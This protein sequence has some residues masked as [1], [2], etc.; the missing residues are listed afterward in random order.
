MFDTLIFGDEVKLFL[1]NELRQNKEAGT[2]L[3][4]GDKGIDLLG[5]ATAFTMA[6][7]CPELENDYC[8]VCEVCKK[9]KHGN[10]ADLEIVGL[11]QG[12]SK[13]GIDKIKNTIYKASSSSYEGRKKVFIIKDIESMNKYSANALL[14]IMEEPPKGTFFILVSNTLNILPTIL[15]RSIVVKVDKPSAEDLGITEKVY[16]FFMGNMGEIL[17]WKE[18]RFDLNEI[19][20]YSNLGEYLNLYL[21]EKK[22][23]YKIDLLKGIDDYIYNAERIKRSEKLS[24]VFDLLFILQDD[25]LVENKS[26][27]RKVIEE[28]MHIFIVRLKT[29]KYTEKL[30]ELKQGLRHNVNTQ[31][32]LTLFFLNF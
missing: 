6:M 3:F 9:I 27:E 19:R 30:I 1:K 28:L 24:I 15:S 23:K 13:V 22:L 11:L 25:K 21:A 12:E 4:Y 7:N 2:Y 5:L 8:G 17:E 29:P 32:A 10:Y 31:A 18:E 16:N 20:S 14:K 26:H